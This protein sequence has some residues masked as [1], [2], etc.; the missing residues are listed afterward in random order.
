MYIHVIVQYSLL[1]YI[2]TF[3]TCFKKRKEKVLRDLAIKLCKKST[4]IHFLSKIILNKF[5]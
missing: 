1:F 4:N 5:Y 3:K 2:N